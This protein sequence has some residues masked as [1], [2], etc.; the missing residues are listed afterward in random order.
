[1]FE[2]SE[3]VLSPLN[4]ANVTTV[5]LLRREYFV[6]NNGSSYNK[7]CLLDKLIKSVLLIK[8][9]YYNVLEKKRRVFSQQLAGK[10]EECPLLTED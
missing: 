5:F 7:R 9:L 8:N 1:M 2:I 6:Y 4:A 10:T 3:N